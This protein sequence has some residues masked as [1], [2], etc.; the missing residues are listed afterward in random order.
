MIY[1]AFHDRSEHLPIIFD[2]YYA[3][4]G[5]LSLPWSIYLHAFNNIF[6]YTLFCQL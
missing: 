5:S 1:V 4:T 6:Q 2:C 3:G